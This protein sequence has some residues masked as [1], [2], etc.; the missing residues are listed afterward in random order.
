MVEW[1]DGRIP[2]AVVSATKAKVERLLE[3]MHAHPVWKVRP[4]RASRHRPPGVTPRLWVLEALRYGRAG[5][6]DTRTGAMT[7]TS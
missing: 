1:P 5:A 2:A 7:L 4:P 3:A 6:S